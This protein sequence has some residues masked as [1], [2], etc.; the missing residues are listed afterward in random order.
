MQSYTGKIQEAYQLFI[1]MFSIFAFIFIIVSAFQYFSLLL[2]CYISK[3]K[4]PQISIFG[5]LFS[6]SLSVYT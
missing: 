5:A 6:L 3:E 1:S 4:T 2:L